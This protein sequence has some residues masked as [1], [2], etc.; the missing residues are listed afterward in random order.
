[1][2]DVTDDPR[3]PSADDP[4]QTDAVYEPPSAEDVSADDPAV[5]APGVLS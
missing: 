4:E 2:S 3:T 5:A 1:V